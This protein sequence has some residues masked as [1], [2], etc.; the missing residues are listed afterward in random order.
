MSNCA[1]A[2]PH[3]RTC[4]DREAKVVHDRGLVFDARFV[5]LGHGERTERRG[6]VPELGARFAPVPPPGLGSM[7][8][9]WASHPLVA[10]EEAHLQ[11]TTG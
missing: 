3:I 6:L 2:K 9:I 4:E 5:A 7:R 1:L 11:G 8:V 10:P